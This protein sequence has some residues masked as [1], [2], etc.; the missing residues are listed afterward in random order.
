VPTTH[1]ALDYLPVSFRYDASL[2]DAR[3]GTAFGLGL[4]ANAWYS[5]S[6]SNLQSIA[7]SSESSGHW[8]ILSP[9][10]SRDLL[11]ITNWILS[12]HAE[13]QWV[14][15]P[16][17]SNE[18]FGLGGVNSVRG[19]REGE[20]FGDTGWWVGLEQKTPPQVVGLVYPNHPLTVRASVYMEYGELYLLDPQGRQDRTA[21]WGTGFGGAAS[22]G[23]TWEAR[24][25]VSWPLLTAG[26]TEAGQP[27]FNFSLSAQF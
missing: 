3:G 5:G 8:V 26:T 9:S 27:R 14:N 21:L 13:G 22:I 6:L 4:G 23:A 15:E 24:L 11:I 10:L 12:F 16:L 19:Y 1:R 18:Q 25:L 20:V 7:G 2:P 17:I